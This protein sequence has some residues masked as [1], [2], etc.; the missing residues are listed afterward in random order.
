MTKITLAKAGMASL[1]LGDPKSI[2]CDLSLQQ[3][4][5]AYEHVRRLGGETFRVWKVGA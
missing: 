1:W 4:K 2:S 3:A 5:I